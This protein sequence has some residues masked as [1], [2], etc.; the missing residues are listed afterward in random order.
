MLI[1]LKRL[2][3]S[4][5]PSACRLRQFLNPVPWVVGP[6]VSLPRRACGGSV[7]SELSR[8]PMLSA[9]DKEPGL[10]GPVRRV[11]LVRLHSCGLLWLP[12]PSQLSAI[13]SSAPFLKKPRPPTRPGH[14]LPFPGSTRSGV[15]WVP[16]GWVWTSPQAAL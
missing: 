10:P 4:V 3:D 16:S 5:K 1:F 2:V 12:L 13:I 15:R 7:S 6:D 8:V 14:V 9:V 11:G